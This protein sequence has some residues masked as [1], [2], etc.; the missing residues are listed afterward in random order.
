MVENIDQTT[1]II[2][3]DKYTITRIIEAIIRSMV[4][5]GEAIQ[6]DVAIRKEH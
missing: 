5:N 3:V 1:S 2:S 6:N 4:F